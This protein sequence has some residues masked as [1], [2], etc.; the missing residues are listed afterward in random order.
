MSRFSL[1]IF[2]SGEFTTTLP[3]IS[4]FISRGARYMENIFSAGTSA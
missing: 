1:D 2:D 3:K 4:Q